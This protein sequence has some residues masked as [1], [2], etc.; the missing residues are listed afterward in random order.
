MTH[1][2]KNSYPQTWHMFKGVPITFCIIIIMNAKNEV[3]RKKKS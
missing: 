2:V 1:L 3:K